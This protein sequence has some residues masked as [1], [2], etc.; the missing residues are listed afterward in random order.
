[1]CTATDTVCVCADWRT[2]LLAS[3]AP[4][5]VRTYWGVLWRFFAHCPKPLGEITAEDV[6]AFL[7]SYPYRS[8]ARRTYY[9]ALRSFF[10]YCE[11]RAIILV[12]PTAGLRVPAVIEKVPR[13]LSTDEVWRVAVAAYARAPIRGFFVLTLYYTAARLTEAQN[14]RW[15][16]IEGDELRIRVAKGGRE[17]VVPIGPGLAAVLDAL[18]VLQPGEYLFPRSTQTLWKWCRDAG[19]QAGIERVHP[20]LLRSTAATRMLVKGARPHAVRE[21]LGHQSIRT[22]QRYWAVERGDVSR[23]AGML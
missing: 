8:A 21:M 15:T 4:P 2:W 19:R 18:R 14:L 20:H 9:Q 5:T 17:R 6:A 1:M 10:G 7:A 13:A 3:Y 23:A 16:D 11:Q 22:T 12:D